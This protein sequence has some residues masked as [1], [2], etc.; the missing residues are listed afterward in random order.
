MLSISGHN[1]TK[2]IHHLNLIL[3]Y[4]N[5]SNDNFVFYNSIY[6]NLKV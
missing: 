4:I 1:N 5:H 3:I 6:S 2:V